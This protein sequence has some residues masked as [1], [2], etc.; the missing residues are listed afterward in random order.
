MKKVLNLQQIIELQKT[1]ETLIADT[2]YD[3]IANNAVLRTSKDKKDVKAMYSKLTKLFD[4]LNILKLAKDKVNRKKT[5]LGKTNQE[6]I[7]ELS[8]LSREKVLLTT[9]IS[10]KLKRRKGSVEDAYEFMIP[11]GDLELKLIEVDKRISEIKTNM[12]NFNTSNT[13]KIVFYTELNLL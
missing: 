8:N 11:K 4:Q 6:L 3:I 13:V 1:V 2:T 12:T 10:S 5:K 9:L 7:L